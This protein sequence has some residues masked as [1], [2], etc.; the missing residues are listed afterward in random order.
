MAIYQSNE[1]LTDA[2]IIHLKRVLA[3]LEDGMAKATS[4]EYSGKTHTKEYSFTMHIQEIE[5]NDGRI[6]SDNQDTGR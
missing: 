4:I 2:A 3:Q 1:S 6:R 5:I